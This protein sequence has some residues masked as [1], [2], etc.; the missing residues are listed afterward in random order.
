MAAVPREL[1]DA[2][3][4]VGPAERI[5]ERLARWKT[6]GSHGRF[7]HVARLPRP[8]GLAGGCGRNALCENLSQSQCRSYGIRAK[9]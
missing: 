7:Q 2:C 1:I 4:L 6:A 3:A 5:R 9:T 8:G